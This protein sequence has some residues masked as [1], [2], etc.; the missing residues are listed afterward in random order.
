MIQ[1]RGELYLAEKTIRTRT[2]QSGCS[3]L[4]ATSLSCCCV[5]CEID[6]AMP[7]RPSSGDRCTYRPCAPEG[8]PSGSKEVLHRTRQVEIA[9]C[10]QRV[11][12]GVV[13]N[14]TLWGQNLVHAGSMKPT[15]AGSPRVSRGR[16]CC[17]EACSSGAISSTALRIDRLLRVAEVRIR[18]GSSSPPS[19]DD[20]A[21]VALPEPDRTAVRC[22]CFLGPPI[23]L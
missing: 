13:I 8:A 6:R 5:L 17:T 21:R 20:S 23:E 1:P 11:E 4:S 22:C 9:D 7:P 2:R 14:Q 19:S 16:R 3:T 18:R 15:P 12:V 10:P